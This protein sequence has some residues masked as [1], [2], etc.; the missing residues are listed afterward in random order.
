MLGGD[1][2]I[3]KAIT[4]HITGTG[5]TECIAHNSCPA[6]DPETVCAIQVGEIDRSGKITG[7]AEHDVA[8]PRVSPVWICKRGCDDHVGKA[9]AID[10]PG[11][12][13][14]VAALVVER[15]AIEAE[16][17]GAIKGGKSNRG[18]KFRSLAEHH[19]A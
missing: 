19:I 7:L 5:N 13:Y 16:A 4:I 12:S 14:R 15:R 11:S 6:V 2:H 8:R 18:G 17:I 10:I 9:I 3:R 1:H